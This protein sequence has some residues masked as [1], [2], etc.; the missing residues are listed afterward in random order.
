MSTKQDRPHHC[1]LQQARYLHHFNFV[2]AVTRVNYGDRLNICQLDCLRS[3]VYAKTAPPF[4]HTEA[5]NR[6]QNQ[7]VSHGCDLQPR[8]WT[9]DTFLVISCVQVGIEFESP[10]NISLCFTLI[11]YILDYFIH[12]C[13]LTISFRFQTRLTCCLTQAGLQLAGKPKMTLNLKQAHSRPHILVLSSYLNSASLSAELT[14]CCVYHQPST[15][16]QST[17]TPRTTWLCSSVF[18]FNYFIAGADPGDLF[19]IK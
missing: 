18:T 7:P 4:E 10:Y 6:S 14:L 9:A 3:V 1:P 5:W 17:A 8:Q 2:T 12:S 11:F 13:L 15:T 19:F 16:T